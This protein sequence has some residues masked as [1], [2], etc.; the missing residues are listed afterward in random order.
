[1]VRSLW[2][3][4][5]LAEERAESRALEGTARADVGIVGGGYLGLWSALRL[6]EAEPSLRIVLIERDVCG[7][8]ASGRNHGMA[9]N[10][11]RRFPA[12]SAV[13][14]EDE[15][16]R[17]CLA[18]EEAID[19]LGALAP[20]VGAEIGF[21]RSG[22]LWGATCAA[23]SG[24]WTAIN[25]LLERYQ[26]PTL[27]PLT[28]EQIAARWN[29]H[30][31]V[32]GVFDASA[33]LV[34]PARLARALRGLALSKGVEIYEQTPMLGLTRKSAVHLRT[35]KG[36]VIA[37][38]VVL[39]LNAWSVA[40]REL[41]P[42]LVVIG[43]AMAA[44]APLGRELDALGWRERTAISDS[45][46]YLGFLRQSADR[47]VI[48]GRAGCGLSFGASLD[49]QYEGPSRH[50]AEL[51]DV[52]GRVYPG[53]NGAA[54]TSTWSGP[55]DRTKSGL[56]FFGRLSRMPEVVY[57]FGFS[58]NGI[59][60][61]CL[62]SRIVASLVLERDDIWA[63]SGLIRAPSRDFPPEPIR[64][65]GAQAVLAAVKRKDALEHA[66]RPVGGLTKRLADLAPTGFRPSLPNR[67]T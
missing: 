28:R 18:S 55:V 38:R 39:A 37:D 24:S 1:M 49:R 61:C 26:R 65:L 7:A 6:K 14:G 45:R 42:A 56:P 50:L 60:P 27:T 35:P 12:L 31:F 3:E 15:A 63:R 17:L 64:Y 58:G 59:V 4:Q 41:R 21:E 20:R 25:D 57:G 40:F 36:E 10:L 48:V 66:G 22:W 5:A 33:A 32:A 53:L 11:W 16:L 23:Q 62:G 43:T 9:T 47:R 67:P 29:I 54:F 30:A 13:C 34:Q 44:T 46:V 8:G 51:R 2:L 19:E 52:I